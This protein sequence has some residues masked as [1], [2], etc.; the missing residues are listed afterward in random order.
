MRGCK[1]SIDRGGGR[2]PYHAPPVFALWNVIQ[3][4][5]SVAFAA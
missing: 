1:F 2:I 4:A 5:A 3:Q